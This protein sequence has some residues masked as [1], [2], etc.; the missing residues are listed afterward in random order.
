MLGECYA[1]FYLVRSYSL[2]NVIDRSTRPFGV[3]VP[4]TAD[5]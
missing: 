2:L 4:G 3:I 1:W 5:G